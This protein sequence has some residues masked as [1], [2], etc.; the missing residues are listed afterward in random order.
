MPTPA[1]TRHQGTFDE[2]LALLE[3]GCQHF[4][5]S[6]R[7]ERRALDA[8]DPEALLD[9]TKRKLRAAR[10]LENAQSFASEL[11]GTEGFEGS[12][13]GFMALALEHWETDPRLKARFHEML[14]LLGRCA[15]INET[16]R[17]IVEARLETT[18]QAL[19]ILHGTQKSR[20]LRYGQD[21]RPLKSGTGAHRGLG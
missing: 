4:F 8:R 13:A 12:L 10:Q 21:G 19:R 18:D 7:S 2:A 9:A 17:Q 3:V 20:D 11:A 6:L 16:A 1:S 14:K 15:Q 5:E